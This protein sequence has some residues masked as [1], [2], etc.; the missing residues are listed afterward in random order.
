[1]IKDIVFIGSE[2]S[3]HKCSWARF[4][5]LA[6]FDYDSGYGSQKIATD[7]IIVFSDGAKMWR[8]EYD[9]AEN[10]AFSI[11]FQMP[12]EFH[13]ITTLGGNDQMW[14]TLEQMHK[15][16]GKYGNE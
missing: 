1:M 9:G 8:H 12:E 6:D 14:A 11:P 2:K 3:G 10:W 4:R 15:K 16:G 5:K 7:L 13:V